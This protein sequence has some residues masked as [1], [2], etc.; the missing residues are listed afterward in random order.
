LAAILPELLPP[1]P[2]AQSGAV[3]VPEPESQESAE[4]ETRENA[5]RRVLVR[6]LEIAGLIKP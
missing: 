5:L 2:K 3:A 4:I 1:A 6:A